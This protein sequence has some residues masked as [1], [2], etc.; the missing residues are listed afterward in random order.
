M[1]AMI[2]IIIII[3]K[4]SKNSLIAN[5]ENRMIYIYKFIKND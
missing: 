1:V 4:N 2:I 3:R 5:M